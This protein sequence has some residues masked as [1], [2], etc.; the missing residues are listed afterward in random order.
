MPAEVLHQHF[1][2]QAVVGLEG[3]DDGIAKRAARGSFAEGQ[4]GSERHMQEL[5]PIGGVE[6][7]TLPLG[8]IKAGGIAQ[9]I[10]AGRNMIAGTVGFK[11]LV[12]EDY[13]LGKQGGLRP[14][15]DPERL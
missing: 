6:T 7:N 9:P 10:Q 14:R 15:D 4:D 12:G 11:M 1:A 5:A 3:G 13:D 8:R 2:V